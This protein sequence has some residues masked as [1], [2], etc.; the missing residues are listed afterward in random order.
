[1]T[2]IIYKIREY[3]VSN[4]VQNTHSYELLLV[5]RWS[6]REWYDTVTAKLYSAAILSVYHLN[7][8]MK[9]QHLPHQDEV[10]SQRE[11]E[12]VGRALE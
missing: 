12:N 2:E 7:Q 1:M 9:F 3:F 6:R 8:I 5:S 11:A 10:H 4:L